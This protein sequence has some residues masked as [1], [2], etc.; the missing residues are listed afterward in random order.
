MKHLHKPIWVIFLFF[1]PFL[2]NAQSNI[3]NDYIVISSAEVTDNTPYISALDA[4]DWEPYRLQNQ[5]FQ[6]SFDNGFS[7]ELKSA[8]EMLNLGYPLNINEYRTENDI[9]YIPPILKLLS[10]NYIGMVVSSTNITKQ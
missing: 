10:G 8:V 9:G 3:T 7:I 6:L 4:A 5:R 2:L 1:I